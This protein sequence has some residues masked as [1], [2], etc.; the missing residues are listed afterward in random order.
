[1]PG[2]QG[3]SQV[4]VAYDGSSYV[5]NN[6]VSCRATKVESIAPMLAVRAAL[7]SAPFLSASYGAGAWSLS[8]DPCTWAH[9]GCTVDGAG[10]QLVTSLSLASASVQG[11][12]PSDVFT[13]RALAQLD[14]S[15]NPSLGGTIGISFSVALTT[16]NMGAAAVATAS[17][18]ALGLASLNLSYTV[19]SGTIPS[20]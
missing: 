7:S 2:A 11:T 16:G 6:L 4:G 5:L 12:L 1:M 9:V 19:M 18:S 14:V 15:S 8:A 20:R 10:P 3:S 13:L 17:S